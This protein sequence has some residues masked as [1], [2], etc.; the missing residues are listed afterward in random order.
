M[1]SAVEFCIFGVALFFAV[2]A[3]FFLALA[4]GFGEPPW[5]PL[6]ALAAAIGVM[7]LLGLLRTDEEMDSDPHAAHP[8]PES[9][10]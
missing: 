9:L 6:A 7:G 1:R 10:A 2:V 3:A 4:L 5:E 8:E